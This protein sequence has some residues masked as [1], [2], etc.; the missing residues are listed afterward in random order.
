M[1]EL[2]TKLEKEAKLIQFDTRTGFPVKA[3]I[4]H[5]EGKAAAEKQYYESIMK[6]HFGE[7]LIYLAEYLIK[8]IV[9]SEESHVP[10]EVVYAA[11]D[12]WILDREDRGTLLEVVESVKH[13]QAGNR[14]PFFESRFLSKENLEK[15]DED[16]RM[17]PAMKMFVKKYY[18]PPK[19]PSKTTKKQMIPK[20]KKEPTLF[21]ML[22][23]KEG[24]QAEA[25]KEAEKQESLEKTSPDTIV[26]ETAEPAEVT[27]KAAQGTE[28]NR[29][30][31]EAVQFPK[32][33]KTSK[34]KQ[35]D[36]QFDLFSMF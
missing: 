26:A 3:L 30:E 6:D 28:E 35:M 21:D 19:A 5:I 8:E 16:F 29:K 20:K 22:D 25:A 17:L 33:S 1:E 18:V 34:K 23:E 36:G 13:P 2:K 12:R 11:L 7:V 32:L 27:E 15:M 9:E 14:N 24:V 31:V 4:Q 10:D